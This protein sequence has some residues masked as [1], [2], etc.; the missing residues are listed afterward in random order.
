MANLRDSL[1]E[2]LE[3]DLES[4]FPE[5]TEKKRCKQCKW[6]GLPRFFEGPWCKECLHIDSD[7]DYFINDTQEMMMERASGLKIGE[8]ASKDSYTSRVV[9]VGK[10]KYTIG[11]LRSLVK[12]VEAHA[13]RTGRPLPTWLR[14]HSRALEAEP[15]EIAPSQ[16][17]VLRRAR[18]AKRAARRRIQRYKPPT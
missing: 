8:L 17:D 14:A 9:R 7:P 13:Q 18:S 6:E 16:R 5:D 10:R 3:E 4:V 11:T 2:V 12:S 1:G 15:G